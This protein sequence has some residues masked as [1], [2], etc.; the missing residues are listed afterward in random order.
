MTS[1]KLTSGSEFPNIKVA[2]VGGG[3]ITLGQPVGK[4]MWQLISVYRGKHCP[5][6][7]DTS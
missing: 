1:F 5:I 6:A 2:R 4:A 3:D 7:A